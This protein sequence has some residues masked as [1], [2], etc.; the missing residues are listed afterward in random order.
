MSSWLVSEQPLCAAYQLALVDLDGVVYVGP[1]PIE[2][3]ASSLISAEQQGMN[4]E[5]TT[6]NSSRF[7]HVVAKQLQSF[8]LP[9]EPWQ[10]ITSSV[11][12]AR[13]VAHHVPQGSA[14][15]AIGAAHLQ[16]EVE[17][18]GLRAVHSLDDQP[19]AVIQGWYPEI[20]W[21]EL[22]NAAYAVERGAAYFVTNRDLTIPREHGVAPG[23]GS[24]IRAVITATGVE[25]IDS[26]GKPGPAMY[27]EARSLVAE[28]N[29]RD[30]HGAGSADAD[31]RQEVE[32]IAIDACLAV[33]DRLD[34]DIEAANRGGYDSLLVL[35]GVTDALMV[36]LAEP[37]LRP[38]YIARDLRGLLT[39][40]HGVQ[41]VDSDSQSGNTHERVW[42][43][44]RAQ[45]RVTAD[46]LVGSII[47]DVAG[48]EI[49]PLDMLRAASGACW[50]EM[51]YA[52]HALLSHDA[53][54]EAATAFASKWYPDGRNFKA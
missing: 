15:L 5:Y 28:H 38:T 54:R 1:Q 29:N 13:M 16:E 17:R 33:G 32:P 7:Q 23:C 21:N 35:T 14:V 39:T 42:Q 49:D 2:Y 22:A 26:A 8:H 43:S 51:D 18:A 34:T 12:A 24:L 30:G 45:V 46:G 53:L 20:S 48:A 37:I 3:A 50:Y 19:A 36:M 6:N 10:V 52:D 9:V 25:P 27:D 47:P 44:G 40:H 11:V 4:I 41:R 31:T